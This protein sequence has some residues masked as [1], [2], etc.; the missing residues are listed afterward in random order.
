MQWKIALFGGYCPTDVETL[1]QTDNDEKRIKRLTLMKNNKQINNSQWNIHLSWGIRFLMNVCSHPCHYIKG[2]DTCLVMGDESMH[3]G[4]AVCL[5]VSVRISVCFKVWCEPAV[6]TKIF[7][8]FKKRVPWSFIV[9][10]MT[11]IESRKRSYPYIFIHIY[12]FCVVSGAGAGYGAQRTG[13]F[14][15]THS[16]KT[17]TTHFTEGIP[18]AGWL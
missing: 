12:V 16:R 15:C 8:L 5:P 11:Q 6:T 3:W 4:C 1:S 18:W 7:Q 13:E 17:S 14:P 2:T 9:L 10:Y